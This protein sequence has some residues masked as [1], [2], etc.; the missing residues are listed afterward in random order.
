MVGHGK[1]GGDMRMKLFLFE[2]L[3]VVNQ[4]A[5]ARSPKRLILI[6]GYIGDKGKMLNHK[7]E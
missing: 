5:I 3:V 2:G 7:G 6:L 1:L 4:M